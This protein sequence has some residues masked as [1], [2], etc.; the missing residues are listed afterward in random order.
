M[1]DFSFSKRT[2]FIVAGLGIL[3]QIIAIV[4]GIFLWRW[5]QPAHLFIIPVVIIGMW[6]TIF[7]AITA[8]KCNPK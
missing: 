7:P 2:R 4:G 3:I 1:T 6:L 5:G 8:K